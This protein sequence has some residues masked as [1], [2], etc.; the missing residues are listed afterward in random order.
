MLDALITARTDVL[1]GSE[2]EAS[3]LKKIDA[4]EQEINRLKAWDRESERY[5]LT[6][7]Y[8]GTYAYVLK[9]EMA[10]GEPPQRLCQPCY[11]QRK[12]GVLH[13]GQVERRYQTYH[14]PTCKMK[15]EMGQL[16]PDQE[17]A[18]TGWGISDAA[19]ETSRRGSS[20]GAA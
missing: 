9:P 1:E 19:V 11:D 13:A 20:S 18:P 2:R 14:C 15:F 8:P 7:F 6:R 5:K 12:K 16:T 17:D 10:R 3:L 4:L